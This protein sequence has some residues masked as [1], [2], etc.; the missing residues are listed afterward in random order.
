MVCYPVI[1]H[2]FV[3]GAFVLADIFLA[4]GFQSKNLIFIEAN[5]IFRYSPE[6]SISSLGLHMEAEQLPG[7]LGFV[8]L[9]L[10]CLR[11]LEFSGFDN[12]DEVSLVTLFEH[13]LVSEVLF[14]FIFK[15]EFPS[16][17]SLGK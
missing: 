8:F 16:I 10:D 9:V 4:A 13:Y 5:G 6:L 12:I 7:Y 17:N 15:I 2:Y 1:H 11:Q 14:P 3:Q